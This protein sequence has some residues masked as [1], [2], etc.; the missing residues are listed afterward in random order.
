MNR[1]RHGIGDPLMPTSHLWAVGWNYVA[2][3]E[4]GS[5][6]RGDERAAM[7]EHPT[8]FTKSPTCVVGPEHPLTLD[9]TLSQC[10]DYEAELA[11]VIDRPGMNITEAD[12]LGHVAGYLVA[13]DV[14]A[15]DI[16][17][18][19]GGQWSKGKSL[20]GTCPLGPALVSPDQ[21]PDPQALTVRCLLNGQLM[22]EASTATMAF[23]VSRI[24]AELS[25]G[26]TLSRGDIILTGTPA[27][28]GYTR[29]PP[30]FLRPG[31]TLVTEIAKGDQ[32]IGRLANVVSE[33]G[34]AG[35][36]RT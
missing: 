7:P 25:R 26:M 10:W 3:F 23:P 28:V 12:A 29:E 30:V 5:G 2:H 13:N 32:V 24:I 4:E 9:F 16:Q 15:R 8:F 22:Q 11:V 6:R 35:S 33:V 21:V 34:P 17:R 1:D 20:D 27:G 36:G 14:T 31:D 19:H 18:Q